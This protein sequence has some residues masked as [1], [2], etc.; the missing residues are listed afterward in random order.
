MC[1][2]VYV[3]A[4]VCMNVSCVCTHVHACEFFPHARTCGGSKLLAFSLPS[5]FC[6]LPTSCA[7]GD[8]QAARMLEA[9]WGSEGGAQGTGAAPFSQGGLVCALCASVC[10]CLCMHMC[11]CVHVCMHVCTCMHLC[12]HMC[13]C[14][15]VHTI[16]P[17]LLHLHTPAVTRLGVCPVLPQQL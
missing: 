7:R 3:C 14:V 1:V 6:A 10:A 2:C 5:E 16:S 13:A 4:R 9:T 12:V 11:A 17:C 15:C 8:G